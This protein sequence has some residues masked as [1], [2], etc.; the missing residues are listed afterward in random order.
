MVI[1]WGAFSFGNEKMRK[2]SKFKKVLF[3]SFNTI[4]NYSPT[5]ATLE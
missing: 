2:D 3:R 1:F 5:M 4:Q